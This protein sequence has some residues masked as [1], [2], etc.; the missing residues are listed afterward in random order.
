MDVVVNSLDP[1]L[2]QGLQK[3][4]GVQ[5]TLLERYC[6]SCPMYATAPAHRSQWQS[7]WAGLI[8]LPSSANLASQPQ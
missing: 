2:L 3:V 7:S 6:I 8:N 1:V 5:K 4:L